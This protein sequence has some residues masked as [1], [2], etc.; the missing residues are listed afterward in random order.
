MSEVSCLISM[1]PFML[2]RMDQKVKLFKDTIY[3][4]LNADRPESEKFDQRS[5]TDVLIKTFLAV[6]KSNSLTFA[7]K[8]DTVADS[9]GQ[10]GY[11][12][13]EEALV[14]A[15]KMV[16]ELISPIQKVKQAEARATNKDMDEADKRDKEIE[17]AMRKRDQEA[18]DAENA[19]IDQSASNHSSADSDA[20]FRGSMYS[21]GSE[22]SDYSAATDGSEDRTS[23][24]G[25]QSKGTRPCKGKQPKKPK[26][27]RKTKQTKRRRRMRIPTTV[28]NR[29]NFHNACHI[30]ENARNYGSGLNTSCSIGECQCHPILGNRP[31]LPNA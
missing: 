10:D 28:D 7:R 31:N 4:K 3:E 6:S 15:R 12:R 9:N 11:R 22:N 27:K 2:D 26:P 5:L 23:T 13:M 30:A 1:L 29:P 14:Q 18:R 20:T 24:Q 25:N 21:D 19:D 16:F 8:V 17:E